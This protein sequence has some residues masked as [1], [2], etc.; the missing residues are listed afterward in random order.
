ML[1]C[2]AALVICALVV[3]VEAAPSRPKVHSLIIRG[4]RHGFI[5]VTIGSKLTPMSGK[6]KTQGEFAAYVMTRSTPAGNVEVAA[7]AIG[8]GSKVAPDFPF[9]SFIDADIEPGTYRIFLVADGATEI[10]VPMKGLRRNL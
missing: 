1:T 2:L 9:L 10:V 6:I 7:G 5:D 8:L 3:P 4:A